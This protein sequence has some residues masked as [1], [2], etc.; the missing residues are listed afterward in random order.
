MSD[1]WIVTTT[2]TVMDGQ[3][4]RW[5]ATV[6]QAE[7]GTETLSVSRNGVLV[8]AYLHEVPPELLA[9]AEELRQALRAGRDVTSAAT[10]RWR[11]GRQDLE[12]IV[13]EDT[14]TR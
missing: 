5:Y 3:V 14:S 1:R 10:H 11:F 2:P 8:H 7:A 4:L 12:P 13:A 6:R 9:I